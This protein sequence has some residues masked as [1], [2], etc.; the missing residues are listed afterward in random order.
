M[1]ATICKAVYLF[2]ILS[3]AVEM[4]TIR[5]NNVPYLARATQNVFG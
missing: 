3:S 2:Y 5:M 4:G 1:G